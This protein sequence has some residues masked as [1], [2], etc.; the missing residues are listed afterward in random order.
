MR[1]SVKEPKSVIL[2][3]VTNSELGHLQREKVR[4][5][6]VDVHP[7]FAVARTYETYQ[8]V[9]EL[10]ESDPWTGLAA[11]RERM[12]ARQRVETKVRTLRRDDLPGFGG[13]DASS[14]YVEIGDP[15]ELIVEARAS[16][17][18]TQSPQQKAG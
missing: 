18:A 10:A 5:K 13:I 17:P 3:P 15:V 2:D 7:K 8:T 16:T 4:V 9:P 14:S 6:V 1:F 11:M 12:L